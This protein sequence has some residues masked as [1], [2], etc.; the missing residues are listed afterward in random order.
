MSILDDIKRVAD[1]NPNNSVT[2]F[3]TK[4]QQL[5]SGEM[6]TQKFL[7]DNQ[8]YQKSGRGKNVIVPGQLVMFGYDPKG[9]DTLPMYDKF[10]LLL[11]FGVDG[12]HFIGLNIHYMAPMYRVAL[13]D[14]LLVA[15][16]NKMMT[17]R[18]KLKTSWEILKSASDQKRLNF[19]V[20]MYLWGH[21][22]TNFIVI[23]TV[24]WPTC[25]FLPLAR[26]MLRDNRGNM[27]AA[28]ENQIWR[29][30]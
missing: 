30:M 5:T 13:L 29:K 9:K 1:Y 27:K 23:P 20:K 26:F 11:P 21:V 7:G 16:N 14:K 3:K 19:S 15:S 25:C 22:K 17:D 12:V 6:S 2:W 24:D 8:A 18:L 4:V 10:P 28:T